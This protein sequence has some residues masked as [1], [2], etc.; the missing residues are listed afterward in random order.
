M[1]KLFSLVFFSLLSAVAFSQLGGTSNYQIL[2][3]VNPARIAGLGGNALAVKDGDINLGIINPSLLDSLTD[4]HLS[5]SYTL[6]FSEANFGNVSY[7]RHYKDL[8]TF[9]ANLQTISYGKMQ[10]TDAA[11]NELGTFNAGE[12]LFSLGYGKQLDSLFSIGANAKFIY[13]ELAEYKSSA[14]AADVA[15]TYYKRSKN[16]TTSL[17]FKN[18]GRPVSSYHENSNESLPFEIQLGVSK[19]LKN[20]P[21]RFSFIVENIQQW[22]LTPEQTGPV[23]ID[24]LTGEEINEKENG[25]AENL[26]RHIVFNTEL[27]LTKNFNIRFGYNYGRRQQLKLEEK[28]G[29]AGISFGLGLRISKFHISYAHSVYSLAGNSNHFTVSMR[30]NDFKRFN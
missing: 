12:Y 30:L 21:L 6:F 3:S 13:S 28:P 29:L 25:F 7:A 24:P 27:L 17:I 4:N 18:I 9:S 1:K 5:F 10:N 16:F 23:E 11:G 15:V 19:K 2:Q 26:M 22:D 8:G 20:A 14:L